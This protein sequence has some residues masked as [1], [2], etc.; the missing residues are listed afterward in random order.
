MKFMALSTGSESEQ[1]VKERV[2]FAETNIEPQTI[3][4]ITPL[5]AQK[6]FRIYKLASAKKDSVLT[7]VNTPPD[8]VDERLIRGRIAALDSLI[9]KDS[10]KAN[11]YF[12]RALLYGTIQKFNESIADYDHAIKLEPGN[13][14][15]WFSRANTRY[16]LLELLYSF[17]DAAA[18]NMNPNAPK[19]ER[20]VYNNNTYEMVIRDYTKALQLNPDLTFAW[21]NRA[22]AEI[23][24]EDYKSATDDYTM[25]LSCDPALSEVYYNRGLLLILQQAT[26]DGCMDLSKAGELGILEAYNVMRRYCYK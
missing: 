16:K 5:L 22:T 21:F 2:Q 12:K 11:N 14:L 15:F 19:T 25:A 26:K 13:A 20:R 6:K 1:N 24:T 3:F 9:G 23:K 10:T 8:S 17:D 7:L 18:L 4:T